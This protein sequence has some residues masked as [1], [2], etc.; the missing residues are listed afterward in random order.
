MDVTSAKTIPELIACAAQA[1]PSTLALKLRSGL[2]LEKYTY[3][4]LESQAGRMAALLAERGIARGDRVLI[5]GANS[6]SWVIAYLGSL[7]L[8]AVI[9]PLDVR[10]A[11]GFVSKVVTQTEPRLALVGQAMLPAICPLGL[12]HLVL[13]DLAVELA[14]IRP[15]ALKPFVQS[16]DLAEIMYTSGTTGT[17]KGVMLTHR[18]VTS[19]VGM[20]CAVMPIRP[21]FRVLSLLPLS[22]MYEQIVGLF[23]PL[24]SGTS[25]IY[26]P[27]RQPNIVM[28]TLRRDKINGMALVPQAVNL[29]MSAVENKVAERGLR[30]PWQFMNHLAP[31]L[32]VKARRLLF[33]PV[34]R[35]LGGHLEF[36][37]IGGASLPLSVRKKWDN[38]GIPVLEGYGGC[39]ATAIVSGNLPGDHRLG[40][41]GHPVPGLVVKIAPDGEI[42]VQGENI[43]G[44][45][46]KNSEATAAA[47][48][49]GWYHSGD[50]GQFDAD[51]YLLFRGRKKNLIALADGQKVHAEDVEAALLNRPGIRD[52]IVIGLPYADKVRVHAVVLAVPG[53][54]NAVEQSVRQANEGLMLHQQIKDFTIWHEQDFPRTVTLKV[55]RHEV[56]RQLVGNG[57]ADQ[58]QTAVAVPTLQVRSVQGLVADFLN[59]SPPA[60]Q[61][62][63]RLVRDL[64]LDSLSMVELLFV[65]E[66]QTGVR[67]SEQ[68]LPTD[69]TVADL[70]TLVAEQGGTPPN[71]KFHF[72]GWTL[73]PL[74]RG[75]RALVQRALFHPLSSLIMSVEVRGDRALADFAGPCLVI[76]NHAS[77]LDTVAVMR[78][79]PRRLQSRIAVGAAADYWYDNSLVG[80]LAGVCYNLY[81]L[82]RSGSVRPSLE[83]T[84]DLLDRGWS[85]L[86]FPEGTRA[87]DGKMNSFRSGIGLLAA[88]TG[89]P[90]L[91]LRVEG[92]FAI[93]PKGQWRPRRGAVVVK[94]G[95]PFTCPVG[96]DPAGVTRELEAR[97]KNL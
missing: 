20:A 84:V 93:L 19:N 37:M 58:P 81:P 48:Q 67:I 55:K 34:L 53:E 39:E 95:T 76:A 7:M 25:I 21:G 26:L 31:H 32:P 8:G 1:H 94:I 44:G 15:A 64:G 74:V 68:L 63:S 35:Q 5:W 38:L 87:V 82:V 62:S 75:I 59:V 40:T 65:I 73:H 90:V 10:S 66:E 89:V 56:M 12:P 6:P 27:G 41:V 33:A 36:I 57:S 50:L 3:L 91:P 70:E 9:V 49:D 13:E 28:Q 69:A 78:A 79:L 24:A 23:V 47:L 97:V 51:G 4:E 52:V 43:F 11:P 80:F 17:P 72:S 92:T 61:P 77:H 83:H 46:W 96:S 22:H 29:I 60:V 30:R 86:I 42:L 14:R 18:N 54:E 2:R 88:E 71:E 16:Q 45:Y 85:I